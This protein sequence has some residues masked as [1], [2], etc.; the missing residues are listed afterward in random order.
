MLQSI[1]PEELNNAL[2]S[3]NFKN[4]YEIRLRQGKKILV[5]YLNKLKYLNNKGLS[6]FADGAIV[7]TPQIIQVLM[8]KATK[9]SLYSYYDQIN[10]GYLTLKGGIRIGIVGEAVT[11][12]KKVKSLKNYS[13]LNIRIPH[14][15]IGCSKQAFSFLKQNNT[16]HNTLILSPPGSGKTTFLRDLAYQVYNNLPHLNVLILDERYEIASSVNGKPQLNVGQADILS[17]TSKQFGFEKGI[18]S[19]S[20]QII[21]TD[22]IATKEDVESILYAKGCGVQ[23]IA[24]AHAGSVEDLNTKSYFKY[25]LTKKVFT[26]FVVL[27]SRNKIGNVEGVFDSNFNNL[28]KES[29]ICNLY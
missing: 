28:F 3:V 11:E 8:F 9:G 29:N 7:C 6:D 23:V 14:Q 21:F 4:V 12:G 26:R 2:S 10:Q 13:S 20:P 27:S 15:V 5:N 18:R 16:L 1:L 22:E 24:S 17:G 19:M 25:L